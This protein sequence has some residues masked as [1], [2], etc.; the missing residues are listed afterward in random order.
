MEL[1]LRWLGA[2][3][4][5]H[6]ARTRFTRGNVVVWMTGEPPEDLGIELPDGERMTAPEP[7][8]IVLQYPAFLA[9][10]TGGVMFTATA[11]RSTALRALSVIAGERLHDAV[12]RERGMAYAPA[13][14]YSPLDGA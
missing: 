5:S 13:G 7:D 9:E 2:E 6:W 3:Q 12:R 10:G 11:R 4:V 8:E 14:G 1:G